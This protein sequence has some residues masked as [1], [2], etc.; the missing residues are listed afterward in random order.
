MKKTIDNLWSEHA[1]HECSIIDSDVERELT[2]KAG[3]LFDELSSI[4]SDEQ[5]SAVK[6]YLD[7]L[8][9]INS[10]FAR[11]AFGFGC[12]LGVRFL[13]ETLER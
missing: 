1:I 12:E 6:A 5:M 7:S 11:K 3:R 2:K 13:F 10:I 8:C 9:E 4:L